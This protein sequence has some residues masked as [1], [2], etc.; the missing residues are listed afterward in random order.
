MPT[1]SWPVSPGVIA[2]MINGRLRVTF[3]VDVLDT[4]IL[5]NPSRYSIA[6]PAG[7]PLLTVFDVRV[8]NDQT[9]DL[10]IS[11]TVKGGT[12]NTLTIEA[13]TVRDELDGVPNPT[14]NL[15]FAGVAT[16]YSTPLS[17]L[18]SSLSLMGAGLS[19]PFRIGSDGEFVKVAEEDN[20]DECLVQLLR[21]EQGERPFSVRDGRLFGTKLKTILFENGVEAQALAFQTVNEAILVWEPRVRLLEMEVVE[22]PS[23]G[24]GSTI[25]VAIKYLVIATSNVR[26]LIFPFNLN[27]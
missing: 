13:E 7:A 23:P 1:Y 2:A 6:V 14:W 21:T 4:P 11:G 25:F 16:A 17:S 3:P 15:T 20:V 27:R 5:R 24:G 26:N 22:Q 19:F 9:I 12:T 8:L 10:G 18:T